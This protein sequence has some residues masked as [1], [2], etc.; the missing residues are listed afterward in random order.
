MMSHKQVRGSKRSKTRSARKPAAAEY[1]DTD[2][3]DECDCECS[4]VDSADQLKVGSRLSALWGNGCYYGGVVTEMRPGSC[5]I[6]YYD[7][8]KDWLDLRTEQFSI[9]YPVGTQ[10]YKLFPGYGFYWGEIS[11]SK[12]DLNGLYYEV[13][14]SDGDGEN[15]TDEP[16]SAELLEE[17]HAAVLAAKQKQPKRK[18]QDSKMA[19][20]DS[21]NKRKKM[22]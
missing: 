3:S 2:E 20:T 5:Y 4:K 17:L 22:V 19:A 18:R 6:E 8:D 14:Y 12:H 13:E 9:V 7:G 10:V 11:L 15:I 21:R 1:H 16:D